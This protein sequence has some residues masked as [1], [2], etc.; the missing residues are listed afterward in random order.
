MKLKEHRKEL[1]EKSVEQLNIELTD[2]IKHLF[3][4]RT[5]AVTETAD[6]MPRGGF[7]ANGNPYCCGDGPGQAD[8]VSPVTSTQ[9]K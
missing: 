1:K 6:V 7:N 2:K 5:K 4:L 8:T 3:D 9:K